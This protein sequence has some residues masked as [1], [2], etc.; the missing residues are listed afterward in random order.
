[1]TW[2]QQTL[3]QLVLV[4]VLLFSPQI[5]YLVCWQFAWMYPKNWLQNSESSD[6]AK[7]ALAVSQALF[8]L[9]WASFSF[10][11]WPLISQGVFADAVQ[12]FLA[13]AMSILGGVFLLAAV[14][15]KISQL[16]VSGQF[17]LG[18]KMLLA[19]LVIFIPTAILMPVQISPAF[20][21]SKWAAVLVVALLLQISFA[22]HNA[23][24]AGK[25]R[26]SGVFAFVLTFVIGG[27][28][29]WIITVASSGQESAEAN[30][31]DGTTSEVS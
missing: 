31:E 25:K 12:T 30:A 21:L 15:T 28:L 16:R 20:E 9:G 13:R 10:Y 4:A 24:I 11:L 23:A 22:A 8:I 18:P 26:N 14:A 5:I 2:Q 17:K 6:P 29:A 3:V 27:V 7:K 1:M 19:A